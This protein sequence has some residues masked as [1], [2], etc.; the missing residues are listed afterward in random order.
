MKLIQRISNHIH[1]GFITVSFQLIACIVSLAELFNNFYFNLWIYSTMLK[2]ICLVVVYIL[3]CSTYALHFHDS[4]KVTTTLSFNFGWLKNKYLQDLSF[5]QLIAITMLRIIR[6]FNRFLG[7]SGFRV[8]SGT[9]S[10]RLRRP[11]Q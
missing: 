7:S 8:Y 5:Y 4:A 3:I 2:K 9:L 1:W 6:I 10:Q 11:S